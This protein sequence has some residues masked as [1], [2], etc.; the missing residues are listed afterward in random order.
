VRYRRS[1]HHHHHHQN[2]IE[3]SSQQQQI[4]KMNF[5]RFIQGKYYWNYN[6]GQ[7]QQRKVWYIEKR[8]ATMVKIRLA[9]IKHELTGVGTLHSMTNPDAC[10][11]VYRKIYIDPDTGNESVKAPCLPGKLWFDLSSLG[12]WHNKRTRPS[13]FTT[14]CVEQC[15]DF[16]KTGDYH[17]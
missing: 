17:Y 10:K 11:A 9:R 15:E 2:F 4:E 7:D 16:R 8:T 14:Q 3:S 6:E 12:C 13:W 5:T 1:N